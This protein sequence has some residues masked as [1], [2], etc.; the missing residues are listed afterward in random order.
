MPIELTPEFVR[1]AINTRH[2]NSTTCEEFANKIDVHVKGLIPKK[3]INERRP[4]ESDKTKDYRNKIY[5]P[6]TKEAV[7]KVITSLSKIRRSQDWNIKYEQSDIPKII[8]EDE[9]L[10]YYCEKNYPGFTSLTNWAFSELLKRSLVDANSVVAVLLKSKQ[11]NTNEYEKPEVEIFNSSQILSYEP[12]VYYALKSADTV[13]ER[14]KNNQIYARKIYYIITD[15]QIAKYQ[16]GVGGAFENVFIYEHNF[17]KLPVF[18]VGGV[19]YER[20]NNDTIQESRIADMVPFLDEAARE[21]SDLQAEIVQHIFSEKYIYTN[22]ECPICKGSG[23]SREKDSDGKIKKCQS[24]EGRGNINPVGTYGVTLINALKA[25]EQNIPTPPFGYIQKNTDIPRLQ[26]ERVD[27]HIYKAL[28]SV[29][30]EFLAQKPLN[31]SGAA[32]EVDQDELNNFVNSVAEDIVMVLDKVYYF[33]CQYRYSFVI[34]NKEERDKMLP[35]IPVPERFGLLNSSILM[36]EIQTAKTSNVNPVLVKNMEIEYARKKYNAD[37][38]IAYELES[39]FELDPFYGFNQQDKMTMLSNGGITERDY[40]VSCNIVQF[41]Q[42]ASK[43][44]EYFDKKTFEQKKKII[45]GYAEEIIKE[46]SA[47]EQIQSQIEPIVE[48]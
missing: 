17:G 16:D 10:E 46:N 35:V 23:I 41:V 36:Q 11:E 28:S 1:M 21:Y 25:G 29:N 31:Q 47:K 7:G 33:I 34:P 22:A 24:C 13:S 4:S 19:Y 18:K 2:Q 37:P 48:Q 12:D 3:L 5:V 9:T 45:V 44:N 20:K 27:K 6:V 38:D 26:D 8:K 39:I 14:G 43:E 40:I 42:R 15:T 32:K 30:M